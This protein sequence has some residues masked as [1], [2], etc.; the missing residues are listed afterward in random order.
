MLMLMQIYIHHLNVFLSK[1]NK[2]KLFMGQTFSLFIRRDK[3]VSRCVTISINS[4]SKCRHYFSK[5][6]SIFNIEGVNRC[7]SEV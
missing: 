3:R 2:L 6:Y 4:H 1:L 5:Y 7:R